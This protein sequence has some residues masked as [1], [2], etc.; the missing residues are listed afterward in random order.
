MRSLVTMLSAGA[1]L[2]LIGASGLM[3]WIF[4]VS[5]GRSAFEQQILGAV[6]IAVSIFLALLPTLVVWAWREGRGVFVAL[7]IPVFFAFWALSLSSAVGFAAKNRGSLSEDRS[8]A[9]AQLGE[10]KQQIEEAFAKLDAVG[11]VSP[12]AAAQADLR[13]LEQDWRWQASKFCKDATGSTMKA[14]CRGYFDAQAEEARAGEA[15]RLQERIAQLRDEAR[16]LEGKGAGRRSDDQA[17]VL[18]GLLGLKAATV[19]HGLTLYL[20]V[21][22]EIGAALGLYLAT[23]HLGSA[24]LEQQRPS[25][26]VTVIEGK[27]VKDITPVRPKRAPAPQIAAAAPRRVPRLSRT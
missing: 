13:K 10:L 16:Q 17:A 20:A 25:R 6:S 1:A 3:N 26:A 23:G 12:V 14:F 24:G 18:A 19:E 15:G 8:L 11:T 7:G 4:M 5:L 22:V 9:T 2:T 27:I 21:L